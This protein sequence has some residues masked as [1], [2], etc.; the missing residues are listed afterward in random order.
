M[1]DYS[2]LSGSNIITNL[3]CK[4]EA[5]GSESDSTCDDRSRGFGDVTMSHGR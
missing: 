1:G 3:P 4:R 5:E 2:G